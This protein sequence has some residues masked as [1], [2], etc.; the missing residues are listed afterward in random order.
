MA[1]RKYFTP[2]PDDPSPL[3][4]SC[5]RRV[6]FEEIDM[7]GM[8]WHGRYASYFEDGRMAFGERF[9]L[10][11][12]LFIRE[13]VTAPLV[14]LHFDFKT[15]LH[16]NDEV[17]I[18]AQL[19]WNEAARLDFSYCIMKGSSF[20]EIAATGY[21]VQLFVDESGNT[22]LSTPHWLEEFRREWKK[23]LLSGETPIQK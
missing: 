11:Y 16:F 4:A 1:R 19:H 18:K 7:L 5:R 13:R 2:L 6:R 10:S 22:I 17:S 21:T 23:N 12:D 9:G 8:L 20:S 14:Q 15:P 3:T